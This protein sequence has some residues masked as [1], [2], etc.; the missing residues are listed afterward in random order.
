MRGS[1]GSVG[2]WRSVTLM[3]AAVSAV[4]AA[5]LAFS[6]ITDVEILSHVYKPAALAP[7]PARLAQLSLPPN[8]TV[9]PFAR[10]VGGARM[11]AIGPDGRLLVTQRDKGQVLALRDSDG[12]G[13]ADS[14]EVVV[15][16]PAVHGIGVD[17]RQ[18]YLATV[19][20]VYRLTV[21]AQGEFG[22]PVPVQRDLP[23]GGQHANRTL[24]IGPD[25]ALY[26]TVGSTCNACRETDAESATMLRAM[27]PDGEREVFASGL[28]NTLGFDW[29]PASGELYGFD[30][31]IDWLGDDVQPEEFNRLVSGE[32]YGWPYVYGDGQRNPQDEPPGKTAQAWAAQ[33]VAPVLTY[34]AHA[35]PMQMQFYRGEQFPA[36]YRGDAF[37]ALRGS[38][39][40]KPPSGYEIARV[41]FDE[42]GQPQRIE[43]F[44]TGLLQVQPDGSW[45]HIGR[46]VGLVFLPDGSMLFGDDVNGVIYR[47]SYQESER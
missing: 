25:G 17:G 1:R 40:R 33:S 16:L 39:N 14:R 37:V 18:V 22:D 47:V 10:D 5:R 28:R 23:D 31:G 3:L 45:A 34:H 24:A 32:R 26:I 44:L 2:T 30:H 36:A 7:T 15:R 43:P 38:W 21:D 35:A 6:G 19:D 11:L 9:A 46:P 13:V 41:I 27:P 20:T 4:G 12:D 42:A 8:F 29:S